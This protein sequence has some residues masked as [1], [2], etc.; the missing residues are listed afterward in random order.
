MVN[1]VIAEG[2][3]HVLIDHVLAQRIAVEHAQD[4][5]GGLLAH[6][7]HSFPRH[8][9]DVGR[10]DDVRKREQ[11]MAGGRRLLFEYVETGAGEF[12]GD[13]R[14]MQRRFIDDAAARY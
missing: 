3:E 7:I 6:A 2:S 4:I 11:R 12:A 9:G 5:E 14:V 10:E 8:A 13:Q 1:S